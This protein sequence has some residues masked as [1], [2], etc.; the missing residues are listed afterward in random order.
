M[1]QKT[2]TKCG[3]TKPLT[4]FQ[5]DSHRKDGVRTRCKICTRADSARRMAAYRQANPEKVAATQAKWRDA[6]RD[7]IAA[8][9]A[10]YRQANPEK[11]A[12]SKIAWARANPE[13]M[14]A[15]NAKYQQANPH[16]GWETT[17]RARCR[18]L[19]LTPV[20]VSFT[21]EELIAQYGDACFYCDDGAFEE[22]D[23]YIPITAGGSHA[24][25]NMRPSCTACNSRKRWTTD[26]V[27]INIYRIVAAA[28][29][30][31]LSAA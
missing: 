29:T 15:F 25:A 26:R 21:R 10:A 11:V 6:H 9:T 18:K 27:L 17:Y 30:D 28:I 24:L 2:C 19:G 12:A 14:A 13:K 7:K 23:H 16:I 8:N 1:E 5:R 3:E 4:E 31:H 20:V 22:L